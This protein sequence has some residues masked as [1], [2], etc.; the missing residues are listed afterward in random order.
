MARTLR[1]SY[2]S[3]KIQIF[4]LEQNINNCAS[5][6]EDD[7]CRAIRQLQQPHGSTFSDIKR[8][9]CASSK[10][11]PSHLRS[12]KL[13]TTRGIQSGRIE[14]NVK[15]LRYRLNFLN[16]P[17]QEEYGGEGASAWYPSWICHSTRS[18]DKTWCERTSSGE[19]PRPISLVRAMFP[20]ERGVIII[21]V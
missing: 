2:L 16:E 5:F 15:G 1:E 11:S 19:F 14:Q 3:N 6:T 20:C 10:P 8:H 13:A 9:L 12:L 7:V 17:E 21:G 4:Q 18:S